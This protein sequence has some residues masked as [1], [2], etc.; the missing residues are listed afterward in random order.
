MKRVAKIMEFV[1]IFL[2]FVGGGAMDSEVILVPA[3]MAFLGIAI[4]YMGA[5]I[6]E[7]YA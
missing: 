2:V 1:G 7:G 6:E 3:V 5:R 4:A